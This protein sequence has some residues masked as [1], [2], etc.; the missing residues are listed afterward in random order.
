MKLEL[1]ELIVHLLEIKWLC[2]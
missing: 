1:V 2:V